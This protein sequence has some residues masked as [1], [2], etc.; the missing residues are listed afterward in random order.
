[1]RSYNINAK[2]SKIQQNGNGVA[3][4]NSKKQIGDQKA[5]QEISQHIE[6]L[7]K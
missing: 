2:F 6:Y 3:A 7:E 1:M 5:D 4:I